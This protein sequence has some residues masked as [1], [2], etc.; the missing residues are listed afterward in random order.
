MLS[1]REKEM[2]EIGIATDAWNFLARSHRVGKGH[3]FPVMVT[4]LKS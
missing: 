3:L 4:E 1:G 2:R